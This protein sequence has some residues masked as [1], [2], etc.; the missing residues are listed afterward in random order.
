MH[1]RAVRPLADDRACTVAAVPDVGDR[2]A[3]LRTVAGELPHDVAV[4]VDDLDADPVG[5][6]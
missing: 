2:R 3:A 5:L 4:A 6:A 1:P